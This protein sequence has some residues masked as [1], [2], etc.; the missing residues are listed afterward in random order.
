MYRNE[1]EAAV[2]RATALETQLRQA[3]SG[4]QQDAATIAMLT[5]QLH[6]TNAELAR[7]R[8]GYAAPAYS[9][10]PGGFMYPARGQQVMILG[11]LSL[12][13]CGLMGPVAWSMGNEELR[14]IDLGQTDPGS[15]S[16]ASAGRICGIISTILMIVG[17]VTVMLGVVLMAGTH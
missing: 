5:Q 6:A 15:R 8:G 11:I 1:W 9:P 10:I 14:R 12:V 3:Q 7:L 2:A 13:V 16:N 4:Q 17:F